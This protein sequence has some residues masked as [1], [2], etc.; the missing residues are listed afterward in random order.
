MSAAVVLLAASVARCRLHL[1]AAL[2]KA[3][4]TTMVP[5]GASPPPASFRRHGCLP[6]SIRRSA[7]TP[8][9][10]GAP[11]LSASRLTLLL[12]QAPHLRQNTNGRGPSTLDKA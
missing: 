12:P 4:V 10:V 11:H 1:F 7:S 2:S 9:G 5:L 8:A 3:A 6:F